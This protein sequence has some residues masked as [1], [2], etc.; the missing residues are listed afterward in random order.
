MRSYFVA[1]LTL[2]AM[3]V[4]V[5]PARGTAHGS[6][7][8]HPAYTGLVETLQEAYPES[9]V[10]PYFLPWNA[11]DSRFFRQAG[12]PSYGFS[13]FLIFTTDTFRVD[14]TNERIGLPGFVDGVALYVR[15]VEQLA[16]AADAG[17]PQAGGL[18]PA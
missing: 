2:A 12:I 6:P 17:R 15:V 4:T 9:I 8:D 3:T 7:L 5:L 16:A 13:P 18:P 14:G 10:G 11:T 1:L